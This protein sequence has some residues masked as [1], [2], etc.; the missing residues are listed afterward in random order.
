[1]RQLIIICL[2][3]FGIGAAHAADQYYVF[4]GAEG[5][6]QIINPSDHTKTKIIGEACYC[7]LKSPSATQQRWV[8]NWGAPQ[9]ELTELST[10][11]MAFKDCSRGGCTQR[12]CLVE[13][14]DTQHNRS[15][16]SVLQG[17]CVRNHLDIL[18]SSGLPL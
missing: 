11:Q 6:C 5:D 3:F 16:Q 12:Q 1:M 4:G 7:I 17:V 2:V 10:S 18:P 14:Y 15:E 13:L 8:I 9:C